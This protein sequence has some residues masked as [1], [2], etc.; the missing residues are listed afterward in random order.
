MSSVR[1]NCFIKH[2]NNRNGFTMIE[3]LA[4]IVILGI[5][6][7]AAIV[8]VTRL[9][10]KSKTEQKSQMEKTAVMATQSYFQ[11]NTNELPKAIGETRT[12][13]LTKLKSANYLKSNLKDAD[14]KSCMDNSYV[15]VYKKSSS[16]YTYT[17]YIY[18][19]E[20]SPT[21]TGKEASGSVN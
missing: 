17:A 14:G 13:P 15:K 1:L 18:C 12:I 4:A 6:S 8:S 16:D 20:E 3:L 5:L 21:S 11:A 10:T 7:V 9:I 2:K 19:G